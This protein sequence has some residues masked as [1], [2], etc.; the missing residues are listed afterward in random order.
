[1]T[2]AT[3]EKRQLWWAANRHE[4]NADRRKNG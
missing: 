2:A 1:M 4:I 3:R